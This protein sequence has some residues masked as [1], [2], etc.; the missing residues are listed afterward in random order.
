MTVE[1][2][3]PGGESWAV[4]GQSTIHSASPSKNLPRSPRVPLTSPSGILGVAVDGNETKDARDSI[5]GNEGFQTG[6]WSH[7]PFTQGD[8]R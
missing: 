4:D 7:G 8:D 2:E 3:V 5:G 6:T 1:K